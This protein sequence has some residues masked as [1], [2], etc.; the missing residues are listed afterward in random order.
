MKNHLPK[1][2]F[3][4]ASQRG[5]AVFDGKYVYYGRWG[6]APKTFPGASRLPAVVAARRSATYLPSCKCRQKFDAP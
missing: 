3:H 2:R 1:L 5:Y 4:K 6:G